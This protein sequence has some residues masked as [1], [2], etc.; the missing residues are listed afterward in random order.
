MGV[1]DTLTKHKGYLWDSALENKPHW[2]SFLYYKIMSLD[3]QCMT[4]FFFFLSLCL[5]K[6]RLKN[7]KPILPNQF[8]PGFN[9]YL[10]KL[11][12]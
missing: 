2:S 4:T 8:Y 12:I 9:S 5:L 10:G 6:K 1:C 11:S 3:L 7:K